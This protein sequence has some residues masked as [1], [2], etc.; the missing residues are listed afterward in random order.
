VA[1]A[2]STVPY[3]DH[4]LYKAGFP[5]GLVNSSKALEIRSTTMYVGLGM[6]TALSFSRSGP[7]PLEWT[8]LLS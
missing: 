2:H 5:L 1:K 6:V 4:R 8:S 3:R 7:L